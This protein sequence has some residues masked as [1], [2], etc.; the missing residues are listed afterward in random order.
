MIECEIAGV[1]VHLRRSPEQTG[2]PSFI[3]RKAHALC[4]YS[5]LEVDYSVAAEPPVLLK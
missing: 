3:M 4:D 2:I 5:L 1:S